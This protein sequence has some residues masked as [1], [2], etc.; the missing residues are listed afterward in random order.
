MQS[1]GQG[2]SPSLHKVRDTRCGAGDS[3]PIDAIVALPP[4]FLRTP[5]NAFR[6]SSFRSSIWGTLKSNHVSIV[7]T[8]TKVDRAD[9][10]HIQLS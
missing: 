5:T 10:A 1:W 3:S 7:R 4:G 8:G 9:A 2:S 6:S